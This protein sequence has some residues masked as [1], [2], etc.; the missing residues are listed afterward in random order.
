MIGTGVV[1][2]KRFCKFRESL[3]E[4]RSIEDFIFFA[5]AVEATLDNFGGYPGEIEAGPDVIVTAGLGNEGGDGIHVKVYSRKKVDA[6][7]AEALCLLDADEAD[8]DGLF[9]RC[10]DALHDCGVS[11][12]ALEIKANYPAP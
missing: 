10:A 5:S 1:S 6:A 4:P 11:V 8:G 9:S 7:L 2:R 3:G 12:H